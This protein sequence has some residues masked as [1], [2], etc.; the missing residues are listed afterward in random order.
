MANKTITQVAVIS[1]DVEL[2][3]I[4]KAG[5]QNPDPLVVIAGYRIRDNAGNPIGPLRSISIP[6]TSGQITT[7]QNFVTNTVVPVINAAEGT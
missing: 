2:L 6:L 4:A 1:S 3:R 5:P 7:L